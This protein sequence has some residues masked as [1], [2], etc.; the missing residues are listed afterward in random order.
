MSNCIVIQ[1]DMNTEY[2]Q[3][4]HPAPVK[5]AAKEITCEPKSEG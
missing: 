2:C 5:K 4:M 3:S 1:H